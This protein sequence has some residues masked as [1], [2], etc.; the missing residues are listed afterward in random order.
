MSGKVYAH[1]G[2][3][4][5][6]VEKV[7]ARKARTAFIIRNA[8]GKVLDTIAPTNKALCAWWEANGCPSWGFGKPEVG[9]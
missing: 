1:F 2:A 9:A 5:V 8:R 6:Y 4:Q 3:Q 7:G